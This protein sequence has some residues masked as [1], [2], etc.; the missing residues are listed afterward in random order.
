GGRVAAGESG[1]DHAAV[2]QSGLNAFV[3]A[4][5]VLG[6]DDDA[7]APNNAAGRAARLGMHGDRACGGALGGLRQGVRKSNEF[8]GH[9]ENLHEQDAAG[10]KAFTSAKWLGRDL[11]RFL[12][13]PAR[14]V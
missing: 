12:L 2:W 3:A 14:P 5:R 8:C 1:S 9:F 13:W 4:E 6:G 7:A 10:A 11:G